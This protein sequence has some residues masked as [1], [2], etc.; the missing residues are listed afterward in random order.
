MDGLI[1]MGLSPVS[2]KVSRNDAERSQALGQSYVPQGSAPVDS[3]EIGKAVREPEEFERILLGRRPDGDTSSQQPSLATMLE[4]IR[5]YISD[6]L[7]RARER[8]AEY[9]KK[10]EELAERLKDVRGADT[11][12]AAGELIGALKPDAKDEFVAGVEKLA[13]TAE[14]PVQS[15][16]SRSV[17]LTELKLAVDKQVDRGVSVR[18]EGLR[19]ELKGSANST[20]K[21]PEAA[22]TI[23]S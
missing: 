6:A 11:V 7:E 17:E 16:G 4:A 21:E 15:S 8:D 22:V 5:Q 23:S 10:L 20:A 14:K 3:V 19:L 9:F 2:L 12:K 1:L 13:D 18:F